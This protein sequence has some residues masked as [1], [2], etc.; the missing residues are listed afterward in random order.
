MAKCCRNKSRFLHETPHVPT[1]VIKYAIAAVIMYVNMYAIP[2][3]IAH[4]IRYVTKYA[5]M[6]GNDACDNASMPS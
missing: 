1:Y 5:I 6:Y 4:A 3:L 2:Y